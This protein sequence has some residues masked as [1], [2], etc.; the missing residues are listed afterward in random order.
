MWS[1]LVRSIARLAAIAS[2]APA[3]LTGCDG[4]P[5]LPPAELQPRNVD[6]AR[7]TVPDPVLREE[8][9]LLELTD[10]SEL[11][12]LDVAFETLR[13]KYPEREPREVL[14]RSIEGLEQFQKLR[15]LDISGHL[16]RDGEL[17]FIE[18]LVYLETLRLDNNRFSDLSRL[19]RFE[20]LS[21]LSARG[22]LRPTN[23]GI[24][25]ELPNLRYVDLSYNEGLVDDPMRFAE[26]RELRQLLLIDCNS[27][28]GRRIRLLREQNLDLEIAWP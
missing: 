21:L 10:T 27:M 16:L 20:R 15:S 23:F 11:R 7:V 14:I 9:E 5:Y 19:P 8:L 28:D 24:L 18:G 6:I 4:S 12:E 26:S 22:N 1:S 3:L 2:L 13:A 25:P 17:R